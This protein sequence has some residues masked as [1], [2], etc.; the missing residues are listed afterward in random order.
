MHHI[1]LIAQRADSTI[2]A[3]VNYIH[4]EQGCMDAGIRGGMM[5][6][7]FIFPRMLAEP[8]EDSQYQVQGRARQVR[9]GLSV[10]HAG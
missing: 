7:L 8:N 5:S 3:N 4:L 2:A 6:P 1:S 10:L 9:P